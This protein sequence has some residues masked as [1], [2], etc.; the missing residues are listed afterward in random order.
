[1]PHSVK[2]LL[3]GGV[4]SAI[5]CVLLGVSTLALGQVKNTPAPPPTTQ[6][7]QAPAPA[8]G[9]ISTGIF[10]DR[11][12]G[13]HSWQITRS[14]TLMWDN[15]PYLPVGG[16]FSPHS[17]AIANDMAWQ[18]DQQALTTLKA[19]G[20]HDLIIT[21]S[22]PLPDIPPANLQRLVDYLETNGFRYG[23]GFGPGVNKPLG[24]MVIKPASYRYYERD[25]LTATWQTPNTDAGLV[26]LVET[27]SGK[28]EI[29]SM[30]VVR[31]QG[32]NLSAS[33]EL[34]ANIGRVV[35]LLYPHKALP[36]NSRGVIPDVWSAYDSYRDRLLAYMDKVKFGKGLRFFLD[37][38][39][40]HLSL[41]DETDYLFPDSNTFKLEWE[42][43]LNRRYPNIDEVNK[44]WDLGEETL[45]ST[46]DLARLRPLWANDSGVPYFYDPETNKGIRVMD[47][48]KSNWWVDFITCR[49]ESLLY[50]MN[51]MANGLKQY[52]ANVPVVYTA[53]QTSTIFLNTTHGGYDGLGIA[54]N[55]HGP[56]LLARTTAPAYSQAEQA[57]HPMWCVATEIS[58]DTPST[59]ADAKVAT[60]P[61][62][63]RQGLEGILEDI[64]S[65]GFKGFFVSDLQ[66]EPGATEARDWL[67]SPDALDWLRD[68]GA[69][70]VTNAQAASYIPPILFYPQNDPGPAQLG[71]IP[72][73][74]VMWLNSFQTG[75]AL[76]W[77][78]SFSG[79]VI[80]QNEN[81]PPAIVLTS[82]RGKRETHFQIPDAKL[83]TAFTPNG[84]PVPIKLVAKNAFVITLDSTPTILF[85]NGQPL[86]APQEAAEDALIQLDGLITYATSHN[87]PNATSSRGPLDDA[88]SQFRDKHYDE[89][90]TLARVEL[91][92]LVDEVT[93]YVW[94]EGEWA[95]PNTHTF[96]DK[97]YFR[98]ASNGQVLRLSNTNPPS[99]YGYGVHYPFHVFKE[100]HY[101]IW[102]AA[103][104]PGPDVSSFQW[105]LADNIRHDPAS[106]TPRG[107]L[108]G[109]GQ[110][111]WIL[112]GSVS[113]ASGENT[114]ALY[115]TN[116]ATATQKYAFAVDAIFI[117]TSS[118]PP[119]GNL[120]PLPVDPASIQRRTKPVKSQH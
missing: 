11:E 76:D 43:Y 92:K 41:A 17:L 100:G 105:S 110:F 42:S 118:S 119:D 116:R 109:N 106:P 72:G 91:F 27:T 74:N 90:L 3:S 120:K 59:P 10:S 96:D 69:R 13:K 20:I 85:T 32:D 34:P 55:Q 31:A 21:P 57:E 103:S 18:E 71:L 73:T 81:M 82:L 58:P 49:N 84:S 16:T 104:A 8:G 99:K 24:G 39:A 47:T 40:R 101:N 93:P 1:M 45:K 9:N 53:T 25:S 63:S 5:T 14:H 80:Q 115:V 12:G 4:S 78:P 117:S 114:L 6:G 64:R 89:A 79:Y 15:A 108:Y 87:D 28:N 54:S 102:I 26:V 86:L 77:W 113:L 46:R 7:H 62:G 51:A 29:A 88:A 67:H 23:L 75:Q 44:S 19:K 68:Y 111:G 35:A 56:A 33:M 61:F 65:A 22:Q 94:I 66:S 36:A 52:V 48:R 107:T 112:L 70:I 37:P 83:V 30:N 38:L 97:P 60:S 2:R 50:Y 95:Q 98:S